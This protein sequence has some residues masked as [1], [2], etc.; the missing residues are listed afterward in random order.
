MTFWV[1]AV[2]TGPQVQYGAVRQRSTLQE[3]TQSYVTPHLPF[4]WATS[5]T[6]GVS[7]PVKTTCAPASNKEAEASFSLIGS[8]QVLIQRISIVHSGQVFFM[9]SAMALPRRISSGIGDV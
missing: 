1:R 6:A 9:P 4:S 7:A 3:P 5:A 8:C 2:Y